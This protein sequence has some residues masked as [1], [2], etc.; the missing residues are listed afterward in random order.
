MIV[1]PVGKNALKSAILAA[2]EELDEEIKVLDQ[3]LNDFGMC[4]SQRERD[5]YKIEH[6]TGEVRFNAT[7]S[8]KGYI[9]AKKYVMNR[10][11][12][13][14]MLSTSPRAS[15]TWLSFWIIPSTL[16]KTNFS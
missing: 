11:T 13:P 5:G 9:N 14:L 8:F 12:I 10:N 7:S 2:K 3:V 1:A 4:R 6:Y 16:T 15:L